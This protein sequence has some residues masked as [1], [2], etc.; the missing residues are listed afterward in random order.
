MKNKIFKFTE[1]IKSV[2]EKKLGIKS[3][4]KEK[5]ERII[6]IPDWRTY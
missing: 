2:N 4:V 6:F 3:P 1:F 5:G